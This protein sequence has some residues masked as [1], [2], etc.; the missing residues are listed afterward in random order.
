MSDKG[1]QRDRIKHNDR[2]KSFAELW[3][4]EN[5]PDYC[6][7]INFGHGLL[8]DLFI[9]QDGPIYPHR[10]GSAALIV[11]KRDRFVVATVIQWLGSNCGLEFLQ[12]A[13]EKCGYRLERIQD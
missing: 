4:K 7:C 1:W 9:R 2:E 12:K 10:G 3:E 13:L 11:N 8:Q 6:R 5:D